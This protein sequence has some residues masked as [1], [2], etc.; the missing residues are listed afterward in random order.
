MFYNDT[1]LDHFM[2]PRNVG[3][4]EDA[5]GVGEVGDG[6]CDDVM[7][8]YLRIQENHILAA[9][10]ETFGCAGSIAACSAATELLCG[11]TI[12]Q[13]Q[14]LDAAEIDRV[15]GGLPEEKAHCAETAVQTI[16]AAIADYQKRN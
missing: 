12:E 2:N 10:F 15:L 3:E 8:I 13:A 1:I 5:D 11:R 4:M 14:A 9:R 7:K 6:R 16:K